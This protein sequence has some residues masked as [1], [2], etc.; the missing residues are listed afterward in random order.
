MH[1]LSPSPCSIRFFAKADGRNESKRAHFTHFQI[2]L[3]VLMMIK[4]VHYSGIPITKLKTPIGKEK[5]SL[6]GFPITLDFPL[7]FI[8]SRFMLRHQIFSTSSE[9][10]C[11]SLIWVNFLWFWFGN[12]KSWRWSNYRQPILSVGENSMNWLPHR[13][14]HCTTFKS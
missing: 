14:K 3:L 2:L 7:N 6:W 13:F 9:F 8:H 10:I 11:W 4:Y 5:E 12:L 1:R